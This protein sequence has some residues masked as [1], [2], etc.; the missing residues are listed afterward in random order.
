MNKEFISDFLKLANTM[1]IKIDKTVWKLYNDCPDG[2][3]KYDKDYNVKNPNSK[4]YK[5]S[6]VL[7]PN[8]FIANVSSSNIRENR[9]MIKH[10]EKMKWDIKLYHT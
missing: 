8:L 9:D 2:S 3:I 5:K 4:Y 6:I 10:S 7:Q 1:K